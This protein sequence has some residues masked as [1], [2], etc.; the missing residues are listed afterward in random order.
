MEIQGDNPYAVENLH[1][2]FDYTEKLCCPLVST[3]I[4]FQNSPQIPKLGDAQVP[5]IKWDTSVHT[6]NLP[7]ASTDFQIWIENETST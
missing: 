2:T 7:S 1:N 6:I 4:T 3:W 5:Y